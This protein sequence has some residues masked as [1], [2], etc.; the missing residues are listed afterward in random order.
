MEAVAIDQE[1]IVINFSKSSK[2]KWEFTCDSRICAQEWK[3]KLDEAIHNYREWKESNISS[4]SEFI[5]LKK[6]QC[7]PITKKSKL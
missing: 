5:R 1:K 6:S 3:E 4:Y 7:S 2:D